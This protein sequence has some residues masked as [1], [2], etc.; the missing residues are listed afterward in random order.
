MSMS[1][2]SS[3]MIV[4]RHG[5]EN[6]YEYL[7]L[8]KPVYFFHCSSQYVHHYDKVTDNESRGVKDYTST[9]L[10]SLFIDFWIPFPYGY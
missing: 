5:L 8:F 4:G 6:I 10:H 3:A 2:K 9:K 7:S 1:S